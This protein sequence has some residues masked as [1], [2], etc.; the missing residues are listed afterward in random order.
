MLAAYASAISADDPLSALTVGERPPPTAPDG[1]T[2]VTMRAAAL[3]HH[4]LWSLRGVGLPSDRLPMILGTDGAGID[5]EGREVVVHPVIASPDWTGDETL[6]PQRTLLSEQFDGT[7]AERVAVPRRNVV[8]K[9]RELSFEEAACLPSAWLTA[10][11]ML[12]TQARPDPGS[13]LLVQGTQGGMSGALIS[14]ARAAGLDVWATATSEQGVEAGLR[15]GA[16]A[17][18]ERG[19]RIPRQVE[20]VAD[21]IGAD[22]WAH[23]IRSLKPGGTLVT[24]GATSGDQPGA[25]LRHIF[26]RQ[27]RVVGATMGT[28]HELERLLSLVARTGLRPEIEATYELSDAR[29]AFRRLLSGG[30]NG[31]LVL[32]AS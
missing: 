19:A 20:T 6:D 17:V 4:D 5:E 30:V 32:R 31:K 12:F 23:S 7:L 16:H 26:F 14:L 2:T 13:T 24:C 15:L 28:R 11:R 27:L 10:Y 22:T 1:W 9:P 8:P 25:E 3:N 29:S 18:F 21:N